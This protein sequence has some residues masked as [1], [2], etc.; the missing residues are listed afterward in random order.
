MKDVFEKIYLAFND[1][2]VSTAQKEMDLKQLKLYKELE[3]SLEKNQLDKLDELLNLAMENTYC[4][5]LES[6]TFGVKLEIKLASE[7]I[8][9]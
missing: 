3:K 6:F 5:S 7:K 4:K 8:E 1:E 9:N 2:P